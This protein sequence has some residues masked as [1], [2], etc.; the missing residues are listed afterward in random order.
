MILLNMNT[1][2]VYLYSE[3]KVLQIDL[4]KNLLEKS[5][6]CNSY[7]NIPKYSVDNLKK[8]DFL[9]FSNKMKLLLYLLVYPFLITARIL[10]LLLLNRSLKKRKIV[11]GKKIEHLFVSHA[12]VRESNQE[13]DLYFGHFPSNLE[14]NGNKILIS[15][16]EHV[17]IN[18]KCEEFK[19]INAKL[20]SLQIC[21]YL[22]VQFFGGIKI[23]KIIKL[24]DIF[25]LKKLVFYFKTIEHQFSSATFHNIVV[26][27]KIADFCIINKVDFLHLTFEGNAFEEYTAYLLRGKKTRIR[28]HQFSPI[29][30][31]HI[32]IQQFLLNNFCDLIVYC[33]GPVITNYLKNIATSNFEMITTGS[34]KFVNVDSIPSKPKELGVLLL[35]EGTTAQTL[36]FMDLA[37]SLKMKFSYV[38]FTLRAHPDLCKNR[39][40]RKQIDDLKKYGIIFSDQILVKD[41]YNNHVSIF[42]S[43]AAGIESMFYGLLPIHFATNDAEKNIMNPLY[44]THNPLFS[45]VYF[46][47]IV[48]QIKELLLNSKHELKSKLPEIAAGY[49]APLVIH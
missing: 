16:I 40:I 39:I 1:R 10:K 27:R 46:D 24:N 23:I 38:N 49:F 42:S 28:M 9:L 26:S 12:V 35:P 33:S 5:L 34:S 4:A 37:K 30:P 47:E 25:K 32:G 43:S 17:K 3:L 41:F 14:K 44:L 7:F 31:G 15:F 20:T 13:K 2:N 6:L 11:T 18:E 22:Y 45:G 48:D 36:L 19:F 21:N 29:T 8:Y